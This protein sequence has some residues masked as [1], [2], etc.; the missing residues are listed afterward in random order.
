[1]VSVCLCVYIY[2]MVSV[3]IYLRPDV[4]VCIS[5]SWC[6]C[7]W[8]QE[9]NVQSDTIIVVGAAS[10]GIIQRGHAASAAMYKTYY[11][12]NPFDNITEEDVDEYTAEIQRKTGTGPPGSNYSVLLCSLAILDPR[13]GHTM[14]VLSPFIPV[15]R[16]SD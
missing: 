1:M 15:L 3:C 14:D 7:V 16:H 9:G 8:W 4:Y 5:T 10:R 2:V 6:L 12:P 11:A 13:V